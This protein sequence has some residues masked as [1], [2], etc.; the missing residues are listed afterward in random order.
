MIEVSAVV[1]QDYTK[2]LFFDSKMPQVIPNK[3]SIPRDDNNECF[4]IFKKKLFENGININTHDLVDQSKI[5]LE[6]FFHF[7]FNVKKKKLSN[8]VFGPKRQKFIQGML[9]LN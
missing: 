3:I 4:K 7:N 8:I 2:N 6:I 5:D 1:Q 9:A